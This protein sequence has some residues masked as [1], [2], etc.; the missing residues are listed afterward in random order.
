[1]SQ[2]RLILPFLIGSMLSS[3]AVAQSQAG[4]QHRTIGNTVA[5]SGPPEWPAQPV[6][7]KGAPN[8]LV[9]MTDDVGFGSTSAFGGPVPTPH[10]ESLAAQ[11]SR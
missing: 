5:E 3:G 8:V 9:I 6:A 1:M 7:P 2:R 11:G 10:L 4:A